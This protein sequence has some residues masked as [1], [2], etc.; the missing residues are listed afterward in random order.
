MAS[1]IQFEEIIDNK[2]DPTSLTLNLKTYF[3]LPVLEKVLP[4]LPPLALPLPLPPLPRP[5]PP[6]PP[7]ASHSYM[8][9]TSNKQT[10][11]NNLI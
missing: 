1:F 6:R 11:T 2:L 4:V 9:I 3:D 7:R 8:D 5:P 10:Y